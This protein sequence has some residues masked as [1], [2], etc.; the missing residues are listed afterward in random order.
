MGSG[1]AGGAAGAAPTLLVGTAPGCVG[2]L[3]VSAIDGEFMQENGAVI[4]EDGALAV[5]GHI[6]PSLPFV[7]SEWSHR[8]KASAFCAKLPYE[9]LH[10]AGDS[11][12]SE[13]DPSTLV[14]T[15]VDP[16][17]LVWKGAVAEV[18]IPAAVTL[19]QAT[20]VFWT[21]VRLRVTS[22]GR[23]CASACQADP[24]VLNY[25]SILYSDTDDT[26]HVVPCPGACAFEQLAVSPTPAVA[27]SVKNDTLDWNF[28]ASGHPL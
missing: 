26:G 4:H 21:A 18:V 12:P 9:V 13:P 15:P 8:I 25:A 22:A 20:P 3:G 1:G 10:W 16:L 19:T 14:V 5:K 17:S 24:S 28:S 2:D 11:V 7:V 6:A 27:K 23:N